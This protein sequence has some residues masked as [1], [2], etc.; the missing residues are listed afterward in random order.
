VDPGAHVRE[1]TAAVGLARE[2]GVSDLIVALVGSFPPSV[3]AGRAG[4]RG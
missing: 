2:D 1:A 3:E 4:P